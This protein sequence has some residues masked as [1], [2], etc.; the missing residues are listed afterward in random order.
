MIAGS[1]AGWF[2]A[3]GPEAFGA[4]GARLMSPSLDADIWRVVPHLID[5]WAAA[6]VGML[7][8]TSPSDANEKVRRLHLDEVAEL[9]AKAFESSSKD[10]A[11]LEDDIMDLE[12]IEKTHLAHR[13]ASVANVSET[14]MEAQSLCALDPACEKVAEKVS[15]SAT[16]PSVITETF[17]QCSRKDTL[18]RLLR[19]SSECSGKLSAATLKIVRE[20]VQDIPQVELCQR[21]PLIKQEVARH[22]L[23]RVQIVQPRR[24][25][26][27]VS[28]C[29]AAHQLCGVDVTC[30]TVVGAMDELHGSD[31][32]ML[33]ELRGA[34]GDKQALMLA[35][36]VSAEC[37]G[38]LPELETRQVLDLVVN[39][40]QETV[41]QQMEQA[42]P[43]RAIVPTTRAEDNDCKVARQ[44]CSALE[45]C[46]AADASSTASSESAVMD[47]A[48]RLCSDRDSSLAFLRVSAE[49]H[50]GPAWRL[51][52]AFAQLE[53][54]EAHFCREARA[55]AGSMH[56]KETHARVVPATCGRAQ[57]RCGAHSLCRS[58]A[59]ARES[60]ALAETEIEVEALGE[61]LALCDDRGALLA[62]FDL[63]AECFGG[64]R[65]SR[66]ALRER[67]ANVSHSELCVEALKVAPLLGLVVE[68]EGP[69]GPSSLPAPS[70]LRLAAVRGLE[71]ELPIFAAHIA[72][73]LL[74]TFDVL[75][76][77]DKLNAIEFSAMTREVGMKGRILGS[78]HFEGLTIAAIDANKDGTIGVQELS[79]FLVQHLRPTLQSLAES[80]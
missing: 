10:I 7:G 31:K 15:L 41:C 13:V 51:R 2:C 9:A 32:D 50:D 77:D 76:M 16:L 47:E 62:T 69:K 30:D 28:R 63:A 54:V 70:V 38:F 78:A 27:E 36:N 48:L 34:C 75:P 24:N 43:A 6:W 40:P 60:L 5:D 20:E 18:L 25:E 19:V 42:T 52:G 61:A 57:R 3:D 35:L 21:V 56:A 72:K 73:E 26:A 67:L 79:N 66:R 39:E 71:L 22:F 12:A 44:E 45:R 55:V 59:L 17:A 14:C 37:R 29:A 49:C 58:T 11:K 74:S 65:A 68:G 1:P 4:M 53:P 8:S 46:K 64:P 33:A 23:P 80:K